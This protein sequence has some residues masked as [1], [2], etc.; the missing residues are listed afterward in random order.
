[1]F[2]SI[3]RACSCVQADDVW[4]LLTGE[5]VSRMHMTL[6][7]IVTGESPDHYSLLRDLIRG[8][9]FGYPGR[10]QHRENYPMSSG[11]D[12]RSTQ[13]N[14]LRESTHATF[15]AATWGTLRVGM[16]WAKGG[17]VIPHGGVSIEVLYNVGCLQERVLGPRSVSAAQPVRRSSNAC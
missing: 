3:D 1:M 15:H 4:W 6:H 8:S 12:D 9:E 14:S 5:P 7:Q 2:R 16:T 17:G 10:D 11:R 13:P